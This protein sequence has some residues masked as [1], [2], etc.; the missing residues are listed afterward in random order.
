MAKQVLAK[1]KIQ[2]PGGQASLGPPVATALGPHGVNPGKFVSEFNE[3]TKDSPGLIFTVEIDVH[4]DRS[5]VFVVKSPPAS[6]LL[7]R[8]AGIVQGS[9]EPNKEKVGRVTRGQVTEIVKTK[10]ADLNTEDVEQAV[11][12]IEGSARSMGIEIVSSESAE[13][14]VDG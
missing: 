10:L 3:K 11:R 5:F 7:K 8:A 6:V 13:E 1:V 9:A 4:R 2:V 14:Q 12:M